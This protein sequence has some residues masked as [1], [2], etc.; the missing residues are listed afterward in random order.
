M[1]TLERIGSDSA[2]KLIASYAAGVPGARLTQDAKATLARW[3]DAEPARFKLPAGRVDLYGDALP[4]GAVGRLGTIRFRRTTS[5]FQTFAF[6]PDGKALVSGGEGYD[7]QI[8][9]YP[10]GQLLHEISTRPLYIRNVAP[11]PMAKALPLGLS[12]LSRLTYAT[13]KLGSWAYRRGTSSSR[14]PEKQ[15]ILFN[16]HF[17]PMAKCCFL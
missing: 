3:R 17:R 12:F 2:K 14:F 16:W 4:V 11:R 6:L 15:V 7:I 10:N 1:E 13:L 5:Y 8:F 9:D